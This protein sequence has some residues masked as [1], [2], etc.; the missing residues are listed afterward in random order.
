MVPRSEF[1]ERAKAEFALAP[2]DAEMPKRRVRQR[3]QTVIIISPVLLHGDRRWKLRSYEGEFGASMRDQ[4][5]LDDVLS[6][7]RTLPTVE[8]VQLDVL[9]ETVDVWTGL[10]WLPAEHSVL[11]VFEIV[12]PAIQS[13][14]T[15]VP[16]KQDKKGRRKHN[17]PN[18]E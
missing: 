4:R 16:P 17:D 3:R 8:G 6:G 15:L 18:K 12:P 9:I 1:P 7:R 11:Q 2:P 13:E 14:L 10:A 5:F